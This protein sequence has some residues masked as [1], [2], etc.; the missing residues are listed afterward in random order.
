MGMK[1]PHRGGFEKARKNLDACHPGNLEL[2]KAMPP[3]LLARPKNKSR[4]KS[5]LESRAGLN[6][7]APV[8]GPMLVG[9]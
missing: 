7:A 3:A 6:V 8:Q 2:S 5:A 4:Q 1:K 9:F